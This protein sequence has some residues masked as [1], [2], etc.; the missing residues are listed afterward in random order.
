M[1]RKK[2]F[3]LHGDA[4]KEHKAGELE[5]FQPCNQLLELV[6]R[7]FTCVFFK[8]DLRGLCRRRVKQHKRGH[9]VS[10]R[11]RDA[12]KL[13][14]QHPNADVGVGSRKAERTQLTAPLFH[15][16]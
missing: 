3:N 13:L 16:L 5:L 10:E 12:G 7:K 1:R 11:L 4:K 9:I 2:K 15:V 8:D 14:G 6:L